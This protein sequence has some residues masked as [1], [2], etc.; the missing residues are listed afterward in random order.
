MVPDPTPTPT[1]APDTTPAPD[2]GTPAPSTTSPTST[3]VGPDTSLSPGSQVDP[4]DI[5]FASPPGSTGT[6]ITPPTSSESPSQPGQPV[7]FGTEVTSI[8][9]GVPTGTVTFI[10]GST[11]LGST[12]V[13]NNGVGTFTTS[14]LTSGDHAITAVY[15]GSDRLTGSVSRLF[16][17]T[18]ASS[19][20][21]TGKELP[22]TGI[23]ALQTGLGGTTAILLGIAFMLEGR[24]RGRKALLID[25]G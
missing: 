12:P 22:T 10:D 18:V 23:N 15:Q 7:T 21:A 14:K 17:Q 9:G 5:V 3:V 1:P 24:R 11:V 6:T 19:S 16:L 25:A 8:N 4:T 2:A 20:T 13:D